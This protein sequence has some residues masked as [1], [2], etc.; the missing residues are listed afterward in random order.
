MN[1]DDYIITL[2]DDDLFHFEVALTF[3]EWLWPMDQG[4]VTFFATFDYDS[5]FR[6]C[7]GREWVFPADPDWV[8]RDDV[9]FD[10]LQPMADLTFQIKEFHF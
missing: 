5:S 1:A 10:A 8:F 4:M 3:A 7:F 6:E 2:F 9:A